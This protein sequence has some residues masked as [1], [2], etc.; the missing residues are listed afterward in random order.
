MHILVGRTTKGKSD[1][2]IIYLIGIIILVLIILILKICL[3]RRKLLW[4]QEKVRSTGCREKLEDIERLIAPYGFLYEYNQDYFYSR[5]NSWQ[6][7]MDY[8]KAYDKL[9]SFMN[10][11][12]DCEPI[13]FFYDGREWMIELWK[14]Q[15]GITTGA[16]IGVYQKRDWRYVS[17]SDAEMLNMRFVLYR[18]GRIILCRQGR[19]WW[20]TGFKLGMFSRRKDLVMVAEIGFPTME[21]TESFLAACRRLGY[22]EKQLSCSGRSVLICF[23]RPKSGQPGRCLWLHRKWV[24]SVNRRKCRMFQNCTRPFSSTIDKVAY[25]RYAFPCLYHIIVKITWAKCKKK[26]KRFQKDRKKS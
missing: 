18:K 21:M 24:Q 8:V 1:M 22:S 14:G 13:H 20:L 16:E 25:C 6:R 12:F 4:A 15:Y 5:K 2:K 10:M 19:H 11:V 17:V 26:C 23:D 3:F 9:A 7:E